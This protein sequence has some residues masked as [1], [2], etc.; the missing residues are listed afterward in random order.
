MTNDKSDS[1]V[2]MMIG[3]AFVAGAAFGAFVGSSVATVL[4]W[5]L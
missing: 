5:V 2:N 3:F 1:H 4:V